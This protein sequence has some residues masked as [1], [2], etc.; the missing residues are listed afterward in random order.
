MAQNESQKI[1]HLLHDFTS[2]ISPVRSDLL[3]A[4]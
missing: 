2:E 1:D 3:I 4:S